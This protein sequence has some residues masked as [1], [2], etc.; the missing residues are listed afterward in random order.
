MYV[1]KGKSDLSGST[2]SNATSRAEVFLYTK[3]Y[4]QYL[5]CSPYTWLSI[6]SLPVE[7]PF[8]KTSSYATAYAGYRAMTQQFSLA[9]NAQQY[10][11]S[12]AS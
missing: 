10:Q 2:S 1:L 4:L 6:V 3:K 11:R 9:I 7:P 12:I 8:I 5:Q